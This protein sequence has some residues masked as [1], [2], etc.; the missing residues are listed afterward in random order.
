MFF[1]ELCGRGCCNFYVSILLQHNLENT[2]QQTDMQRMHYLSTL[3]V[4]QEQK[5]CWCLGFEMPFSSPRLHWL[6]ELN[7]FFFLRC[8]WTPCEEKL[9]LSP[10]CL[11]EGLSLCTSANCCPA[12]S[13]AALTR[14]FAFKWHFWAVCFFSFF[15]FLLLL[16]FRDHKAV[17]FSHLQLHIKATLYLQPLLPPLL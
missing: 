2:W 5:A 13:P 6:G 4:W 10:L 15:S 11:A 7:F 12:I 16:T 17:D 14:T 9:T 8:H 3:S 1:D